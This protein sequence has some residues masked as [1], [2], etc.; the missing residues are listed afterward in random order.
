MEEDIGTLW[1]W[2]KTVWVPWASDLLM[3]M[4]PHPVAVATVTR[5]RE[6]SSPW[7][8]PAWSPFALVMF[9]Y[10]YL[11]ILEVLWS[12][13]CHCRDGSRVLVLVQNIDSPEVMNTRTKLNRT[14]C[15]IKWFWDWNLHTTMQ[16]GSIYVCINIPDKRRLSGERSERVVGDGVTGATLCGSGANRGFPEEWQFNFACE[17]IRCKPRPRH[18]LGM[19]QL[20]VPV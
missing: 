19:S 2:M 4:G 6:V 20:W 7:T 11:C 8:G 3:K 10:L 1:G 16:E 5:V 15:R 12:L 17:P 18:S 13:Q 9:H 14:F